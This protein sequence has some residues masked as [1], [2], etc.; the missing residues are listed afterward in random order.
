MQYD[1]S[2]IVL[3]YNPNYKKLYGTILS[4]LQQKDVNYE[5]IVA[6]DGSECLKI[7]EIEQWFKEHAFLNYQFVV[8]KD[9]NGTV[10]NL[11]SA[12]N[13]VRGRYVKLISPGDYLY[14]DDVLAKLVDF[15][16]NEKSK[17]CFGKVAGYFLEDDG[18][19][20]IYECKTPKKLQPYIDYDFKKIQKNYLV[21]KDYIIGASFF[22]DTQLMK[23][24]IPEIVGKVRYAEDCAVIM[25]IANGEKIQFWSDFIV[26]YEGGVG[27][28]NVNSDVWRKRLYE[29]NK[30][31]FE[32]IKDKHPEFGWIYDASFNKR[33]LI[34]YV[35]KII[36]KLVCIFNNDNIEIDL[37]EMNINKEKL[38]KY[39]NL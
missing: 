19:V 15:L 39:L 14:R 10:V 26:W 7:N 9:N 31:C 24:Y 25:M 17:I 16:D 22:A 32:L 5:I 20:K 23:K 29:D 18:T 1:V 36:N 6:D 33:K 4:I 35:Y 34:Y 8:S 37:Y 2:V 38:F 12:L 11:N 13:V 27:I 28:S 30:R 21:K 3:T